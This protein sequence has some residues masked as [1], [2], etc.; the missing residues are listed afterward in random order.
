MD[1]PPSK[2]TRHKFPSYSSFSRRARCTERTTKDASGARLGSER[3]AKGVRS[4]GSTRFVM[5]GATSGRTM[6]LL[7]TPPPAI[8]LA[9]YS[10][11]ELDQLHPS[12]ELPAPL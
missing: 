4:S 1:F 11:G 12:V 8:A 2:G 9:S 6:K 10:T 5:R 7:R 3:N